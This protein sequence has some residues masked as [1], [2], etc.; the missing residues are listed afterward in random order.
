VPGP[1]EEGRRTETTFQRRALAASEWSLSAIRPGK[2][3]GAV[4]GSEDDDGV[5]V[6]AKSFSFCIVEPTMSSSCAIPASSLDQPFSG[7]RN[8]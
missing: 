7:V 5:I 3:F 4:V 6:N 8:A 1:A 2:V